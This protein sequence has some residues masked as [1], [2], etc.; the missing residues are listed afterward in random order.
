[1]VLAARG[2]RRAME[3]IDLRAVLGHEGQV[4]MS[5]FFFGLEQAQ[6]GFVVRAQFDTVRPLLN[7]GQADG[8]EGFEEE[9]F[10]RSIIA[11]AE[12]HVVEHEVS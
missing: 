2:Q 12:Y 6:G 4:K 10:A 9:R 11:D 5:G 1:M 8:F 7:D 3:R